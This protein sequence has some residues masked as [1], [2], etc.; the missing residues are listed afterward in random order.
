MTNTVYAILSRVRIKKNCY[1][2]KFVMVTVVAIH[3]PL[4]GYIIIRILDGSEMPIS[5]SIAILLAFTV[6]ATL[7]AGFFL[8]KLTSPVEMSLEALEHYDRTHELPRLPV[9]YRDQAGT[10][11]MR[12]QESL[13]KLND[14]VEEKQDLADLLAK[15]LRHPFAQMMGILEIIKLE[16]DPEKINAYCNQMIVE[17]RKQLNFL[18]YV[19]NEL[20]ASSGRIQADEADYIPIASLTETILNTISQHGAKKGVRFQLAC[21]TNAL[22]EINESLLTEALHGILG[23]SLKFSMPGSII[24]VRVQNKN[25]EVEICVSDTGR[26]FEPDAAAAIFKRFVQLQPG[27]QGE[28]IRGNELYR[29]KKILEHFRGT[30]IAESEGPGKGTTFRIMLPAV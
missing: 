20:N 26:G 17:G 14:H 29:A 2:F 4:V 23:F 7:G 27:T 21:K 24:H 22:V 3:V 18:A 25:R 10:L 1:A 8:K 9:Q 19:V 13:I 11:M 30:V 5:T 15:D 6:L 16:S 28:T 12:L